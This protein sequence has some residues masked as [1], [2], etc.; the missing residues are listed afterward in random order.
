MQGAR[1]ASKPQR[2]H[3]PAAPE[4]LPRRHLL[5]ASAGP[6]TAKAARE[7]IARFELHSLGLLPSAVVVIPLLQHTKAKRQQ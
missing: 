1:L 4:E 6:A 7:L 5:S 2:W 3:M